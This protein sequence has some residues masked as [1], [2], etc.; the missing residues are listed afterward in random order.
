MHCQCLFGAIV[1]LITAPA[2]SWAQASRPAVLPSE[3]SRRAALYRFSDEDERLLDQIQR[4]CFNYFWQEVGSPALLVKDRLKAPCASIA[5]VGFQLSSLPIGVERGWCSR[6]DARR[7]A[8]TILRSLIERD[9][10]KYRGMYAHFPDHHTAGV[11]TAGFDP[12]IST[13][14]TALLLAGVIT[15]A[16]YFGAEVGKLADRMVSDVNWKAF[17]LKPDGFISM[18]WKPA[19]PAN[20]AAGGHLLDHKWWINS[21]EERLVYLFAV[22]APRDEFALDPAVYYKLKRELRSHAD[23]PPFVAS[24]PGPLFTYFFSHCW[25]DYQTLGPDDPSRFDSDAPRV[26][27]FENSRRAVLTH[28]RRCNEC[29]DCRLE[30]GDNGWGLSACVGRDGYI[31]PHVR[32]NLADHDAFHDCTI[33]PYAAGSAI[34]FTRQESMAALRAFYELKTPDGKRL[35]WSDP[36]SGGYGLADSFCI[37]QGF[38]C[39]DYV[40]IDEGPLLLAIENA[41]TKLIWNTFMKSPHVQRGLKRLGLLR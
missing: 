24:W 19:D 27:W 33:T 10:N 7:R 41:R 11:N 34:M 39:D 26:D 20:P 28:K 18:A 1:L 12:E 25:I 2:A 29:P 38:V 15:A 37:K 14:D 31:V 5:A 3:E 8:E 4:G 9:D 21:D 6:D 13:V 36:S 17:E 40:G 35:A 16:E 22:G 23:L 32:P 30:L